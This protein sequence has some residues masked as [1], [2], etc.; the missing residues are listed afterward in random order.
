MMKKNH[1]NFSAHHRLLSVILLAVALFGTEACT[2]NF[3]KYNTDPTGLSPDQ[4]KPDRNYLGLMFPQIQ[5]SIYYNY[6]NTDWEFQLQQNLGADVF[7]GYMMSPNPFSTGIT[8]FNYGLREGWNGTAFTVPYNNVMAPVAELARLGAR[9]D[10]P[11]FWGIALILKVEAMHRVTDVYGPIPYS[12][13]GTSSTA[14]A[15]DSQEEVYNSMFKDLDTALSNLKAYTTANPGKTPFA[16]FDMVYKG[17]YKQWI[18]FANSLRLRLAIRISY[19]SKNKAKEEGEKALD[20]ANGGVLTANTDNMLVSGYGL[21]HPLRTMIDNWSDMSINASIQSYM[22]GLKDPR[23]G[24]YMDSTSYEKATTLY[25]GIRGGCKMKAKP[26]YSGYSTPNFKDNKTFT[27]STPIQLM[28]SAEVYFLRAEAALKGWA[29]A[30]GTPQV[31][32]EKGIQTSMEQWG[33]AAGSSAYLADAVSTPAAYVDP[34]NAANNADVPSDITVKW[35]NA[36]SEEKKLERIITQKWIA[37]FPE[38]QEAWSEFRRTAYPK[39]FPPV[40]NYSNNT[41]NTNI[42][43]R[44]LPFPSTEYTGNKAEVDKA[45]VLLKGLDNGGTRLWWDAKP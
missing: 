26:A 27:P 16:K 41:I 17:D 30:D 43:I 5:S 44:R 39:I 34:Q 13:Y 28:T 32:Y 45:I 10:A 3:E 18:K 14:A 8:N 12:K 19:A 35:D 29:N 33:V 11:D 2:K 20:P 24:K 31:L 15:Y 6:N 38:G 9:T 37:M 25:L 42:Q 40:E 36:A 7:S 4:L 21:R 1:K 22:A 23:I